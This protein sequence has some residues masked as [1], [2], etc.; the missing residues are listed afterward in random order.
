MEMVD[1]IISEQVNERVTLL[2]AKVTAF[3][4]TKVDRLK[5]QALTELSEE[6]DVFRNARLFESVRSLMSL[7]LNANDETNVVNHVVSEQK[8]LQEELEVLTEQLN[9]LLSENEKLQNTVKVLDNKLSLTEEAVVSLGEERQ[10]LI[11]EVQNLHAVN[12]ESFRS[13]EKAVLISEADVEE[14]S[15]QRTHSN[16]FLTDEVMKF[17][18]F[19]NN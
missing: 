3:L 8:E 19:T 13:S 9:S 16:E 15:E 11:E 14:V 17:M 7:E 18:P 4:R 5:D 10:E 12:E 6:S 2:E 1:S